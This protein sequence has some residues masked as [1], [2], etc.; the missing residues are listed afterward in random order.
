MGGL[1]VGAWM[2]GRYVERS[3][4]TLRHNFRTYAFLEIAIAVAAILLPI[5]LKAAVPALAWAYADGE[6]PARFAF[7]RVAISLLLVGIP[8]AAMGATFPVAISASRTTAP[9]ALYA[10]NTTGA[11]FGA[12]A[13][14]FWLIPTLGLR[15]T[16]WVGVG[17]ERRSRG[18]VPSPFLKF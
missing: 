7:I 16:T 1:A 3:A 5:A 6:A 4:E 10:A 15:R 11:A 12:I 13:A 17:F 18:S 2:A 8:A 9:A 14:G